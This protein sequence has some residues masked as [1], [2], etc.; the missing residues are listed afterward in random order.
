MSLCWIPIFAEKA[1]MISLLQAQFFVSFGNIWVY[2]TQMLAK[3]VSV[4]RYLRTIRNRYIYLLERWSYFRSFYWVSITSLNLLYTLLFYSFV[5][6]LRKKIINSNIYSYSSCL[7]SCSTGSFC[8]SFWMDSCSGILVPFRVSS[9]DRD[10]GY[11]QISLFWYQVVCTS[12]STSP[13]WLHSDD[14]VRPS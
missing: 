7:R 13:K 10:P 9:P 6:L 1:F 5:V 11:Q 12:Q 2:K 14:Q 4:L 8:S 3:N